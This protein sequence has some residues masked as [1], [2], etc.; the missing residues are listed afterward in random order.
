MPEQNQ[1]SQP[2]MPSAEL[3]SELIHKVT[4]KVWALLKEDL[5][6]ANERQR[7]SSKCKPRFKGTR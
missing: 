1:N 3:T 5:R 7:F 4:D 6:L 2:E